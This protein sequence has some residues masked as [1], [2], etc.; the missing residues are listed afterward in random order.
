MLSNEFRE[1][2]FNLSKVVFWFMKKHSLNKINA[3]LNGHNQYEINYNLNE[4]KYI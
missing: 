2:K 4:I 3:L 1:T